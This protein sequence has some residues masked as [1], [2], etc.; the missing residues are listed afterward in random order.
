MVAFIGDR[1]PRRDADARAVDVEDRTALR[2]PIRLEILIALAIFALAFAIRVYRLDDWTGGVHGDEGEAGMDALS[3]YRAISCRPFLSGWF[4]QLNF[5]YW[6]I[7]LLMKVFGTGLG[8]VRAFAMLVGAITVIPFYFM[9]RDWFGVRMAIIAATLLAISDVAIS[10]AR[11]ELSTI[12]TP[13]FLVTGFLFLFRG[14]RTR[15]PLDFVWAGFAFMLNPF[16]YF[17]GRIAPIILGGVVAYLFLLMPVVRVPGAYLALRRR[18]PMLGRG[19]ALLEPRPRRRAA[20]STTFAS[21]SSSASRRSAARCPGSSTST[22]HSAEWNSRPLEKLIFNQPQRMVQQQG[23]RMIHSTLACACRRPTMSSPC[24]PV[25]F[26]HTPISLQVAPDGFWPR[27]LWGQLTTTLSILTYRGDA[28]SVYTFTEEP[29]AKPIEA[30]LIILGLAWAAWRWRDSRMGALSIWFWAIVLSGG[31]L[32]IDAPYMARIMGIVPMMAICA[33]LRCQ[34]AERRVHPGGEPVRAPRAPDA[35]WRR[36]PRPGALAVLLLGLG[37]ENFNDYYTR[38]MSGHPF[39]EVTGQAYFVRQMTA[40]AAAA[41]RPSPRF[42]DL[43]IH[44]IYW[45]H[46][47]QSLPELSGRRQRYGQP[48]QRAT[49]ARRQNRDVYFMVWGVDQQY[50][51]V[52]QSL[53]SR[54]ATP[55]RS[56]SPRR[57]TAGTSSSPRIRVTRN[58][59]RRIACVRATTPPRAARRS[60]GTSRTWA[61]RARPRWA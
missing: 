30:A 12:T 5:Y 43:G 42:Y 36:W 58:N 52:H 18:L 2:L 37:V 10:F 60:S 40:Q 13:L 50:L 20:C 29:V 57:G 35:R 54:R 27:A 24:L 32:T 1:P 25:V 14:L 34:Q 45:G 26:E 9:V 28:S 8:G 22:D 6:G 23:R 44:L 7:A 53:L 3:I 61:R 47:D 41:G 17:G 4:G 51:D 56:T 55:S 48:G 21:C 11:Q 59:W 49:R 38:Y 46:G 31:V 33:A 39:P 19:R 16:F 15:R